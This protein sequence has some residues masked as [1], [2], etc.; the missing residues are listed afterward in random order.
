MFRNSFATGANLR[1]VVDVIANS[2]SL[3]DQN[4]IS[5]I[6]TLFVDN[7][8]VKSA[9]ENNNVFEFNDSDINDTNIPGLQS[10]IK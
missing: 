6:R 4:E 7:T 1:G 5:E 3:V 8:R 2:V 9:T 10:I